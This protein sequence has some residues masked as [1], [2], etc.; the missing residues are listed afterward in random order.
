MRKDSKT[1]FYQAS[2]GETLA[3]LAVTGLTL[4]VLGL[5]SYYAPTLLA[6][7]LH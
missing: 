5:A 7:A 3:T 6:V 4:A 1:E 2:P